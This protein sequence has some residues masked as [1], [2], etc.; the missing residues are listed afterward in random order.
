MLLGLTGLMAVGLERVACGHEHLV[1]GHSFYHHHFFFA[2][3]DHPGLEHHP[4]RTPVPHRGKAPR[5]VAT[6]VPAPALF[7]PAS[8]GALLVPLAFSVPLAPARPLPGLASPAIRPARPRGPP[9]K[10]SPGC[11][12]QGTLTAAR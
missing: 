4:H 9:E 7:Q 6:I 10:G 11:R 5:K 2:A 3:H 8:A 12:A 1:G